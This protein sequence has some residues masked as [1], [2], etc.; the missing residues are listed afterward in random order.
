MNVEKGD[1]LVARCVWLFATLWDVAHQAPLF[2]ESPGN[3]T[4][5]GSLSLFQGIFLAQVSNPG[6]LCCRQFLYQLNIRW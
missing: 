1:V 5:V 2:M 6:L 4:G 3:N